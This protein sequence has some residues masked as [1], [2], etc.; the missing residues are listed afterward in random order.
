MHVIMHNSSILEVDVLQWKR[1]GHIFKDLTW[2][3]SN[4]FKTLH[5][6]CSKCQCKRSEYV[7]NTVDSY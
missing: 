1:Y 4:I 2:A 3:I 6:F 7:K 5:N